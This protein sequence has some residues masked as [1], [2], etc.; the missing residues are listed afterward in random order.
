MIHVLNLDHHLNDT[1]NPRVSRLISMILLMAIRDRSDCVVASINP[2]DP[3]QVLIQ[4]RDKD[5]WYQIVPPPKPILRKMI[6]LVQS[7]L[8]T[9]MRTPTVSDRRAGRPDRTMA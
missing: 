5:K 7:W 6:R 9:T 3:D 2:N 8:P 1:A 4:Y